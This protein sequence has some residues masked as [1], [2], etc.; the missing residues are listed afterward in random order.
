MYK[1][2]HN[3][4][5]L[6]QFLDQPDEEQPKEQPIEE[7]PEEKTT[8]NPVK[9]T[10]AQ[11]KVSTPPV[12]THEDKQTKETVVQTHQ[13]ITPVARAPVAEALTNMPGVQKEST[14]VDEHI[15]I[16]ELNEFEKAFFSQ[17]L[18]KDGRLIIHKQMRKYLANPVDQNFADRFRK[19]H[20]QKLKE[21]TQQ[22]VEFAIRSV[23]Q[24]TKM[25]HMLIK[26]LEADMKSG[27][28]TSA[29]TLM[30]ANTRGVKTSLKSLAKSFTIP[31]DILKPI[32][33]RNI[34]KMEIEKYQV[35]DDVKL[36]PNP[37]DSADNV[38]TTALEHGLQHV[39][40]YDT[41]V[42]YK[43]MGWNGPVTMATF[44]NTDLNHTVLCFRC[45]DLATFYEYYQNES[46]VDSSNKIRFARLKGWLKKLSTPG[47]WV[48]SFNLVPVTEGDTF[49]FLIW[50]CM[51]QYV[52]RSLELIQEQ[53]EG[54]MDDDNQS[55]SDPPSLPGDC[56]I[57]ESQQ[58]MR[59]TSYD[60]SDGSPDTSS[61][62]SD[63]EK[64]K[65]KTSKRRAVTSQETLNDSPA[66]R[67][68]YN[69]KKR[70]SKPDDNE[71]ASA[72]KKRKR[73]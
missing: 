72:S 10:V 68:R 16:N 39:K 9:K 17:F 5:T 65:K 15:D 19:L 38:K 12:Q 60:E 1:L 2:A 33:K 43:A 57:N 49:V 71:T 47:N 28:A 42:L 55:D 52:I 50:K 64:K 20:D 11:A 51:Y 48:V 45:N 26:R 18:I 34:D 36:L 59:K 40:T 46:E 35:S 4:A 8:S 63:D 22:T 13:A 24:H 41:K 73:N 6:Y 30:D 7:Q 53:L 69:E 56:N 67:T 62:Y 23:V 21:Q 58:T 61:D 29:L 31:G 37:H 32:F 54:V 14:T 44:K 27:N 70:Q 25:Q 3:C 66:R